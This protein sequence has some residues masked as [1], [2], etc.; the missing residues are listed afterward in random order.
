M[1]FTS[2]QY[3]ADYG[4]IEGTLGGDGDPLDAIVLVGEPTFPGCRIRGRPMGM[5]RMTD[6]KG[7]DEKILCVPLR[8]PI[9]S[10]V[11]EL[12]GIPLPLLNEIEHFF[13]VYKD[14]EGH[15]VATDGFEGRAAAARVIDEGARAAAPVKA[16]ATG[17]RCSCA[18]WGPGTA[19]RSSRRRAAAGACIAPG[20]DPPDEDEL[21][22]VHATRSDEARARGVPERRRRARSASSTCRRSS[23]GHSAAPT[24]AT[25]RSCRTP[26]AGTCAR[27]IE[28][29]LRHAFDDLGLHRLEANI[30]PANERSI[31]LVRGAGLPREGF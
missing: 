13:Q 28:L 17:P 2:I 14:L 27:G 19:R 26:A 8:D 12:D 18:R 20:C 16:I 6:E 5:F 9:W 15:K 25:T 22:G 31:A 10:L 4:F 7:E 24:S 23:T 30:Q 29:V 11:T 3:P 21:R 1:L